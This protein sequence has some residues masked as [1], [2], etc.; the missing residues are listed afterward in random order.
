LGARGE[1]GP[2]GHWPCSSNQKIFEI[3]FLPKPL[4][5]DH[6]CLLENRFLKKNKNKN[7]WLCVVVPRKPG[8]II[9]GPV[10]ENI[11]F[12]PRM[13]S[14][15]VNTGAWSIEKLLCLPQNVEHWKIDCWNLKQNKETII[16]ILGGGEKKDGQPSV[17]KW[18]FIPVSPKHVLQKAL[19]AH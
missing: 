2:S 19:P 15:T 10:R 7:K 5:L 13:S 11:L 14:I 1:A 3:F 17:H 12:T 9:K 18:H 4:I 8:E 16:I 6:K